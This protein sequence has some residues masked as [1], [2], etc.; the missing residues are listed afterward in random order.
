MIALPLRWNYL[1]RFLMAAYLILANK[2][3]L[4][5]AEN[6]KGRIISDSRNLKSPGLAKR[7]GIAGLKCIYLSLELFDFAVLLMKGFFRIAQRHFDIGE[8]RIKLSH[9]RLEASR[10]QIAL[11]VPK[12]LR[13]FNCLARYRKRPHDVHD[14]IPR[15][16]IE[17]FNLA[18][19]GMKESPSGSSA[20]L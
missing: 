6:P 20:R 16:K 10:I 2:G 14:T 8:I 12:V 9:L 4:L 19:R 3:M 7:A 18:H 1:A 13:D 17:K 15:L 5:V 11:N